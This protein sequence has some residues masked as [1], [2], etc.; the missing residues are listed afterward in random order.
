MWIVSIVVS[1]T[2]VEN[3]RL[4]HQDRRCNMIYSLATNVEIHLTSCVVEQALPLT[5]Y[6]TG[7]VWKHVGAIKGMKDRALSWYQWVT[8]LPNLQKASGIGPC[9]WHTLEGFCLKKKYID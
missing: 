1:G 7:E 6:T 5:C 2:Q 8:P 4:C 9:S 3:T